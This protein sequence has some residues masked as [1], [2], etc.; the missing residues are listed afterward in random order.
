MRKKH[1]AKVMRSVKSW[2]LEMFWAPPRYLSAWSKIDIVNTIPYT[3]YRL[4]NSA[5]C[6]YV[7]GATAVLVRQKEYTE[8]AEKVVGKAEQAVMILTNVHEK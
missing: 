5:T 4:M 2:N 3:V 7:Q 8:V 6:S 1:Q